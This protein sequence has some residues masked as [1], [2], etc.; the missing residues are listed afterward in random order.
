MTQVGRTQ[1][2][3]DT[4]ALYP[5]NTAGEISP[6]DLRAQMDNAADSATFKGTSK[7]VPPIAND[8]DVGTNG[9]GTFDEGDIWVDV[10]ADKGYMCLDNTTGNAVWL[11]LTVVNQ[12]GSELVTA[13]DTE[14]GS[15]SWQTNITPTT[16]IVEAT[17]ARIISNADLA[18]DVII[19]M[20][21]GSANTVTINTGLTALGLVTIIQYGAGQTTIVQGGGTTLNSANSYLKLNVQ[22]SS[23]TLIPIGSDEYTVVGDLV[24]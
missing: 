7:T 19:R 11:E 21:N 3:S 15:S 13:L 20:T 10:T 18:G 24:A 17:T 9:S 14:I 8:D 5:D 1:F 23:I 4:S 2:K 12:T 16:L 6:A 22:Y